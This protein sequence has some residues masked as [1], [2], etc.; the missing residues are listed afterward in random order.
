MA[1]W[2]AVYESWDTIPDENKNLI[3]KLMR[4]KPREKLAELFSREP[5]AEKVYEKVVGK[6]QPPL[7]T[8]KPSAHDT[9][10]VPTPPTERVPQ[11][12]AVAPVAVAA[13]ITEVSERITPRSAVPATVRNVG[14]VFL[15]VISLITLLSAEIAY[16]SSDLVGFLDGALPFSLKTWLIL[17]VLALAFGLASGVSIF[18]LL[19]RGKTSS[20][21]PRVYAQ[22]R[23]SIVGAAFRSLF[24][25]KGGAQQATCLLKEWK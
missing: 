16:Y 9:T 18:K 22:R 20:E 6:W 4:E 21:G 3:V 12:E 1:D 24:K 13:A 10:V 14:A 5:Y 25:L 23:T 15:P 2:Y 17:L 7:P 19:K 8:P 11:K